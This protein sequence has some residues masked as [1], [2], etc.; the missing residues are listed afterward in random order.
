MMTEKQDIVIEMM[1]Q[2]S[3]KKIIYYVKIIKYLKI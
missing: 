2:N 3:K 1:N